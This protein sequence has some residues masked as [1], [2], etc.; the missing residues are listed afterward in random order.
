M[1]LCL[2]QNRGVLVHGCADQGLYTRRSCTIGGAMWTSSDFERLL[3]YDFV[4][5]S[6]SPRRQQILSQNLGIAQF[7]VVK[8]SFEED[9]PKHGPDFQYVTNTA[10]LKADS[11][12]PQIVRPSVVLVADT[13][14][15]CGGQI[16]EKP[17]NDT[18]QL[19][20]LQHYRQNPVKVITAVH[21]FRAAAGVVL[22]H[23]HGCETTE[24]VFDRSLT[25][26]A[27]LHYVHTGEGRDAAGGFKYQGLGSM[28][29]RELRGDYFNVVGLPVKL[30]QAL[31]LQVVA[32]QPGD[33]GCR[34][35]DKGCRPG[36][37]IQEHESD[38]DGPEEHEAGASG[39]SKGG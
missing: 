24:L 30:A 26:N 16:F 34:P 21:V 36:A 18:Q 29:F 19:H 23:V 3:A 37:E 25:D 28:L 27:L 31:V 35:G 15:S 10:K 5:G 7:R 20:M 13:V 6:S 39:V 1:G 8:S 22:S 11:I 14:V 4:L 12:I 17:E 32:A 33:K 38:G 9:L 2:A